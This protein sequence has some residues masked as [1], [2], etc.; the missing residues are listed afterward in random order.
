[1]EVLFTLIKS[2]DNRNGTDLYNYSFLFTAYVDDLTFFLKYIV[3]VRILVDTY[4]VFSGLSELK[5]N[6]NKCEIASPWILRGAQEAVCGL[7]NIDLTNVIIKILGIHFSYN[8]KV[9]QAVNVWIT[10]TLSLERKK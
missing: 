8:K 1:M 4:K 2:K 5:P 3:L 7:Q 10:R 6:I 9:Q